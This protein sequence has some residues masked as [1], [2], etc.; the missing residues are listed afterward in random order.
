MNG[1]RLALLKERERRKGRRKKIR[2]EKRKKKERKGKENLFRRIQD[3]FA[4][5]FSPKL[6]KYTRN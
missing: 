2:G 1:S 6:L 5:I 3:P 4:R